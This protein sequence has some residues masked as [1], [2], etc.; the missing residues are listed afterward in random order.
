MRYEKRPMQAKTRLLLNQAG[1]KIPALDASVL[2]AHALG[3]SRE[4]LI[5]HDDAPIGLFVKLRYRFLVFRRRRGVPVAYLTKQK[6]FFGL[7]FFV[8][9]HV[10]I[11]RPETE[12]LVELALDN[13]KAQMSSVKHELLLVDVGTGSGCIPIAILKNAKNPAGAGMQEV[14]KT[15]AIDS[16]RTALRVAKKNAAKHGVSIEFLHGNLLEPFLRERKLETRDK[17]IITANLPYLT[18]KQYRDEPSIR[19]EPKSALVGGK[20]GLGLYEKLLKQLSSFD[21]QMSA[22]FEIDPS[23]SDVMRSLVKKYLPKAAVEIK[24][25]LCGRDRVISVALPQP[26]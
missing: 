7:A 1:K 14:K 6:E 8:N 21:C 17:V 11:P 18:P 26:K 15:I 19:H 22:F 2:L 25:D 3:K 5:V 24:K 20:T 10:L 9:R 23:Q 12:L 4:Y 16:S 13:M